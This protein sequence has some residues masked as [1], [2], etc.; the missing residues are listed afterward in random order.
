MFPYITPFVAFDASMTVASFMLYKLRFFRRYRFT[1]ISASFLASITRGNEA[2]NLPAHYS[3]KSVIF[4]RLSM[5]SCRFGGL[6][7]ECT[8]NIVPQLRVDCVEGSVLQGGWHMSFSHIYTRS[9][10]CVQATW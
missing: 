3:V 10:T 4:S 5:E 9:R 6:I 1:R 2:T 7:A 8:K